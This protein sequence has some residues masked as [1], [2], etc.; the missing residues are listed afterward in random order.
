MIVTFLTLSG[1][2]LFCM[3]FGR[4]SSHGVGPGEGLRSRQSEVRA[5]YAPRVLIE[6]ARR[7]NVAGIESNEHLKRLV[8]AEHLQEAWYGMTIRDSFTDGGFSDETIIERPGAR[9]GSYGRA[10]SVLYTLA[11]GREPWG[12][13]N[14]T[15]VKVVVVPTKL[16]DEDPAATMADLIEAARTSEH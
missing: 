16:G 10:R 7:F 4:R 5:I 14:P 15:K 9:E 2:V 3:A 6:F 11:G 12:S 8:Q 1:A 13:F